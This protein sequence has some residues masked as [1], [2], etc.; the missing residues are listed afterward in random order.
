M[1]SRQDRMAQN[2]KRGWSLFF[3]FVSDEE[4]DRLV[5]GNSARRREF[6]ELVREI[7]CL[8]F[9]LYVERCLLPE[10]FR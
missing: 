2:G 3:R 6:A 4:L 9:G 1:K 7:R 8:G 10:E 5:P